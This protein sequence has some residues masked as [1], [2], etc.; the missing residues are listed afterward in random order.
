VAFTVEICPGLGPIIMEDLECKFDVFALTVNQLWERPC[1]DG[2]HWYVVVMI[3]LN[4]GLIH[5]AIRSLSALVFE[6]V[7]T[8]R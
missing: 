1:L 8:Y 4:E 7:E 2:T 6:L 3:R 5:M